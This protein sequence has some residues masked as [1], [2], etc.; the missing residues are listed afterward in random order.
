MND[1]IYLEKKSLRKKIRKLKK[2]ITEGQRKDKSKITM[3]KIES[4]KLFKKAQIIFAY[5]AMDDEVDTRD[6]IMKWYKEKT[7][8]LPTIDSGDLILKKFTGMNSLKDGDLY[9]IPEPQ[10]EPFEAF[11]Q[12]DLAIVPGVAFDQLNNRMGRGKAYYDKILKKMKGNTFLIG[13]CYDFQF[14]DKVPVEEHDITMDEV[15]YS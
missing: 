5:W 6:F 8:I 14:I 13:I 2:N 7:I 1:Q 11:D 4:E 9:A 3:E 10:G 12:L 15:I